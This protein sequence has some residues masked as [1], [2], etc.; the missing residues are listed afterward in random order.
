MQ[1]QFEKIPQYLKDNGQFCNWRYELRDG[2]Q[3]KVP[4]MS[5][6]KRKAN[7]DDPTTFVAFDT[8]ASATGYDGIGIRVCGRI[9][10][11]DLDHCMEEGKLLPWAQEIVDRFNVT[12][13]EISPSGEGIRIFALLPDS[14]EYDTQTYYIKKGNIEVYIPGHT[15]RFLTVTG[16][17]INGADVAETAE[18]LTW[19]LDTYMQ[20][21]TPPTPAVAAPG[22]SYLSDD[23]VIVKAAS[24]KNG[25]KF[26]RLW[27]G[28]IT[29][30]KS[31]SEADA[32]LVSILAFWCS[33]DKAQMDRLFRQSCLM[34]EKW[35]SLRGVD[36]YGNT[37]INKMVSRMTDYYK[38]I[39]P[40]SAAEDFGVEWLKE[41]DPMDSSKYPWNDIGAG[42]IF[43]DFFQDRLRY[44]PERKM[45]FHYANGV[46]QP[47]TGNLCAMKYC[48]DLA[49]LMYTF[50][51][52][53]K[54]EDKRKSYMKYASRWQSHSNRVNIL[55]DAQV[56]HP[57]SYGSFDADIY[58]FNCKNGTLHIDTGEF[59]EHRSTDLL[60]KKSPVVY[61]PMAYSGRFA[62]YIDEI[63]SGDAD[64]AKFLQKILGYGL[65]GDTRHECMT[66]LY[67]VTTRNGKGTLCESVLK[68]LGD[69]GCASRPETIAMKSY[70][71][72]SQPSEDVARLAGVR[73]VNIP[74][75]GKG[76]VLDA[77]KVKAMTGND[78]LNARYLHENSF[79]FQP[80]FKIYVNANF[81]PVIND[82]TLFSSDRIIIIPFDRHFDEH[83][84][85]TTLK[86]R[87]AEEDVQSAILNW[88]L[89]GYRLLQTEGLFLP[90]SVKDAT[91][92]YQHDSDKMALFFEDSLVADDTAEV[93]TARVYARY[94]EWCQENGTYPEG[95][96]NFKQGLQAFAEVVRK[97]PKRGGEKTT[98]LIG[99]RLITDIPPLT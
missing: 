56:H 44:V 13:I 59:T 66:I 17:T 3:T 96:K 93:M 89:E 82:M 64:R 33:G 19:L 95:M 29:G 61:D 28:D 63:M 14:F 41:L 98:L 92:R 85:D 73:F 70:T 52:E 9:V 36:S 10:G 43:A 65:T 5:G 51:L 77:A 71:N 91:E 47:D 88:L 32:A 18:A 58:I 68:V 83:S 76:M 75:P 37:V 8:A 86:R 21:P 72:G 30:Y 50:A 94:K 12:Y 7:V 16:N 38:P 87:F 69:Y 6:T 84:R 67:G 22:E 24:S 42:H 62:S 15:N 78:T 23:E 31:Q 40:R 34:R 57:I 90:K 45:W 60:T 99:Y 25:E 54:D 81:L 46:W 35:D 27:N 1:V 26:T 4:Y 2:S 11:I 20:R 80:Q 48:M 97:R 55:K 79:D 49:N 53:I 39:I 74:E